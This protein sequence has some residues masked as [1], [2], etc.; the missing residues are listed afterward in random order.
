MLYQEDDKGRKHI[1]SY[2][3]AKFKDAESRYHSNEQEYLAVIWAINK[4]RPYLEDKSFRLH[5]DNAALTWL[6]ESK[7]KN[8]K[9]SR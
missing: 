2:T 5:T 4:Y 1:I 6:K 7:T 9:W 3:S 8:N